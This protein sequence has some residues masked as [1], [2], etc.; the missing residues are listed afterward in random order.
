MLSHS[1]L[2]AVS[3]R[4]HLYKIKMSAPNGDV[5]AKRGE[6][7]KTPPKVPV[8]TGG[9]RVVTGLTGMYILVAG[10]VSCSWLIG[11]F[12]LSFVWAFLLI[13]SLF[14]IWQ[15]KINK[16]VK[17]YLNIEEISLYR[18]RAFHFRQNETAEWLNFL[19]NRWWVFSSFSIEQLV[20]KRLDERLW[21]I[22]PTF[23]D[24]LELNT[25]ST[26]EQ[27]PIIRNVQTFE[28][29]EGVPGGQPVSWLNVNK[30]P[31]GLD[32]M[33]TFQLVVQFDV[34]LLCEDFRMIFR[35][36]VGSKKVNLGFDMAVE[37][38]Q[39]SGTLQAILHMSMDVPFPH[40]TKAT[41]SFCERPDVTFNLRMMKALQMMEVPLLKSWIHTNV[42]E[43]LTKALVDPAYVD[44]TLA[45][46]GPI[47]IS[48]KTHK[49]KLAQGVLTIHI[50]GTPSKK[51]VAEDIHYTVIRLGSHKRRT[52]DVQAK[53]EWDD[54]C[55]FFIY[56][57]S[58]DEILIKNKCKRLLTSSTMDQMSLN[59]SSFPFQVKSF[60]DKTLDLKDGSQLHFNMQY[61]A[62]P[63]IDLEKSEVEK[64]KKVSANAGVMYVC[65]HGASNVKVADKTGASDP[66]CIL[67]CNRR[68]LLTTPYV[69]AT[70]NPRW[71]SAVEFFVGDFTQNTYSFFVYDWDGTNT[72]DDDFLGVAH[73]NLLKDETVTVKRT[74]TLG[75]NRPEEGF[76]PDKSCGQITVSIVF[77]PIA[78]VAKSERFRDQMASFRGDEYLYR[79]DLVSPSYRMKGDTRRSVSAAAAYMDV[80]LEDKMIVEL[81]LLQGKDLMSMDRNGFSDPF[82][83][84]SLDGK[85]MYT[86]QVKKKTLFPKWN[87][88]VTLEMKQGD[89]TLMIEVFDKDM[90]SKEFMG[91]LTLTVDKLKELSIKEEAEWFT[92]ERAKTGQLQLKCHV[93]CK[94]TLKMT[95]SSP[96]REVFEAPDF[97]SKPVQPMKI[98]STLVSSSA[99]PSFTSPPKSS[100]SPPTPGLTVNSGSNLRRSVSDVT[101]EMSGQG[102]DI[103]RYNTLP[104][105]PLDS[106]RRRSVG[107]PSNLKSASSVNSVYVMQTDRTDATSINSSMSMS[108]KLYNVKGTVHEAKGVESGGEDIYCKVRLE[109]PGNRISLFSGSRVIGKSKPVPPSDAFF[110]VK[111]E[112][113]RGHGVSPDA[114]LIFDIKR[115]SKLHLA[116][117]SFS[118]RQLLAVSDGESQWLMLENGIDL[119]VSLACGQHT[120][121]LRRRKVFKSLSFQ[122]NK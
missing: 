51:A 110:D 84:V 59:L 121:N 68:R 106:G 45:K 100:R 115:T 52:H 29:C 34:Q 98:E 119:E 78:S 39:I 8:D 50:K 25:F 7:K 101:A 22:K 93:I 66:Y 117:K 105:S 15:A 9:N 70:R 76:V 65:I 113:D 111:F 5:H 13:A 91:K 74:L 61:T 53:E 69:T 30:P 75:Y 49:Q 54:V 32:K 4:S 92:L 10:A 60:A 20:K 44:L 57:L 122:K 96:E 107:P 17:H 56:N 36:R 88:Q 28:Y 108:N 62:L 35:A 24:S 18:K 12:E 67:F 87:E 114:M 112:I 90:I 97:P 27:T 23:L 41:I 16:I 48:H 82:C 109:Q 63:V 42:M 47:D 80:I 21:D 71:E 31:A 1:Q 72:V 83:I 99:E 79:E 116:T 118:L 77:R 58:K 37:E 2:L 102:N 38:L 73:L 43:G 26:G 95:P 14:L 120:P 11:Y 64:Q 89:V 6:S 55:T 40:I 3:E 81:T 86:T 85:K 19:V 46:T 104:P 94:D 103:S 33:S